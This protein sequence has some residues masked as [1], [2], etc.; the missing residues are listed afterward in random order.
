MRK[1]ITKQIKKD[2]CAEVTCDVCGEA[3]SDPSSVIW[4]DIGLESGRGCVSYYE[5]FYGESEHDEVDIC[6]KCAK[7]LIEDIRAGKWKR[8][9]AKNV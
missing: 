5:Y 9:E 7:A 1:Y 6:L 3:A 4:G 8:G 2:I